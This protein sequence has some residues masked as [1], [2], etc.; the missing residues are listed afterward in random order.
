VQALLQQTPS[1]QNPLA[2]WVPA[3]HACP[4][5]ALQAPVA[6]QLL[7]PLQLS[8]SSALVTPTH[9]PPPP[10]QAWQ[11]PQE[12]TPQQR[13]SMQF[14]LLHSVAAVQV[15]PAAFL[16]IPAASHIC[17]PLQLS[18]PADLTGLHVPSR[19]V[20]LHA[21]HAPVQ[22]VLQQ[23][24][25]AHAPLAHSPLVWHVCPAAFL[26]THLPALQ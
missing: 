18:S 26:G 14:P 24:P 9:I 4:I 6:S 8:P 13:P 12:A 21:V 15:W 1:A 23:Y 5:F 16:H 20:R 3:V 17:M 10:V 25:S 11:A 22:A 7:V 2:H 19:P